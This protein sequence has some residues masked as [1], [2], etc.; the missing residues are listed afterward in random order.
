MNGLSEQ[1]VVVLVVVN[2]LSLVTGVPAK[3]IINDC[4]NTYVPLWERAKEVFAIGPQEM[5]P[6]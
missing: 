5:F 3:K 4:W 1:S 6:Q 2:W